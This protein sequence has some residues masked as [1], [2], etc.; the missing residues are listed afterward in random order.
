MNAILKL[1]K[2]KQ[3]KQMA[4]SKSVGIQPKRVFGLRNDVIGNVHFTLGQEIIYP[5]AGVIV[6]EDF[7][8]NKQRY[9]RYFADF[10]LKSCRSDFDFLSRF[11]E[12]SNPEI[13]TISP[14]RKLIAVAET[15]LITDK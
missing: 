7:I 8:T 1:Q 10:N 14:N 15:N 6:V 3:V 9:L 4:L 11:P 5:A 13:I 2:L 12:N